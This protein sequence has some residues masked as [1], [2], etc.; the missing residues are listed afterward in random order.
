MLVSLSTLKFQEKKIAFSVLLTLA[1]ILYIF[2]L[3]QF[4]KLILFKVRVVFFVKLKQTNLSTNI[5]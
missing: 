5:T 4:K 2:Q 1:V 3:K